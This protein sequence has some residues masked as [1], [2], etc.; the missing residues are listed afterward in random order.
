VRTH[1]RLNGLPIRLVRWEFFWR[2]Q[3]LEGFHIRLGRKRFV[4]D[5]DALRSTHSQRCVSHFLRH[6][7]PLNTPAI[8]Q[9]ERCKVRLVDIRQRMEFLDR[10]TEPRTH[11]IPQQRQP[12]GPEFFAAASIAFQ[13]KS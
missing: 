13:S 9:S 6:T 4:A 2:V 1:G 7:L 10:Q 11:A 8:Q 12:V 3:V 5:F